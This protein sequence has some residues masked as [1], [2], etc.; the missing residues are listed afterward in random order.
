MAI[1]PLTNVALLFAVHPELESRLARLVVMG[2]AIGVGGN[3]SP[4]GEFNVWSDPEAAHRVL[5]CS[6]VPTTLVPLDLTLTI[7]VDDAWLDAVAASGPV[8]AA[9]AAT[10]ASYLRAYRDRLGAPELPL[11][12]AVAALEAIVPGT[13]TASPLAIEVDTGF[14]PGR[15]ATVADRR[16]RDPS[17]RTVDVELAADADHVRGEIV[18]RLCE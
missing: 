18:R 1:G 11:H 2:G 12:D 15:G 16:G 4:A 9:L 17:A 13:L 5:A 6:T 10:R 7:T 3:V 8:G 14:G